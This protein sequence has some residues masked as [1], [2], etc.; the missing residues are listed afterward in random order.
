MKWACELLS[1]SQRV[2]LECFVPIINLINMEQ[3][4]NNKTRL[5]TI[6]EA[7]ALLDI[8]RHTLYHL[9]QANLLVAEPT[10]NGKVLFKRTAVQHV[11]E[12]MN[13]HRAAL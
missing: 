12:L 6:A 5:V 13:E 4:Q 11:L 2:R 9:R 7:C 8:N 1:F 3:K 10:P